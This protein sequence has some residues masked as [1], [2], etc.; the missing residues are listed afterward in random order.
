MFAILGKEIKKDKASVI[1]NFIHLSLC[2][3]F[4]GTAS[5]ALTIIKAQ[6][7]INDR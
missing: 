1:V 5:T 6:N 2:L 3:L 4:L 7:I